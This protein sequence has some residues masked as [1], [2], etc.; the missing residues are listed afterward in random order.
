MP[1]LSPRD[2][3]GASKPIGGA[4]VLSPAKRGPISASPAKRG[5]SQ[6]PRKP[7][8][9]PS[10]PNSDAELGAAQ[11]VLTLPPIVKTASGS[12]QHQSPPA[13]PAH[14]LRVGASFLGTSHASTTRIPSTVSLR[15][16]SKNRDSHSSS[17]SP[18]LS[19]AASI[20]PGAQGLP[21][22]TGRGRRPVLGAD[23]EGAARQPVTGAVR[24]AARLTKEQRRERD[25]LRRQAATKIQQWYLRRKKKLDWRLIVKAAREYAMAEERR[26]FER[27]RVAKDVLRRFFRWAAWRLRIVKRERRAARQIE[28]VAVAERCLL[29]RRSEVIAHRLR[30]ER[31]A[32]AA[33]VILRRWKQSTA[34]ARVRWRKA[35]DAMRELLLAES[36]IERRDVE[37]RE[38]V[39]FLQMAA[40]FRA[41]PAALRYRDAINLDRLD[42]AARFAQ[43]ERNAVLKAAHVTGGRSRGISRGLSRATVDMAAD[44]SRKV[45]GLTRP[46]SQSHF[47]RP[48]DNNI[49]DG[50]SASTTAMSPG[51]LG[52]HRH[53]GSMRWTQRLGDK[54]AAAAQTRA[55]PRRSMS[56]SQLRKASSAAQ[57]GEL[58]VRHGSMCSRS[59]FDDRSSPAAVNSPS[60]YEPPLVNQG[61]DLSVLYCTSGSFR[62]AVM[63]SAGE[64]GADGYDAVVMAG[65]V[66]P[67]SLTWMLTAPLAPYT[68]LTSAALQAKQG[69]S[70]GGVGGPW[71]GWFRSTDYNKL[72][73][74]MQIVDGAA[75]LREAAHVSRHV[76]DHAVER[77]LMHETNRRVRLE[78]QV[79]SL[80]SGLVGAFLA[81]LRELRKL[82]GAL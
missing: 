78:V 59:A 54:I 81:E 4:K 9:A 17:Q 18:A 29:G 38:R 5:T 14:S 20:V 50:G 79:D 51:G 6:S 53:T 12:L 73:A 71:H 63:A 3:A 33:L 8:V 47:N 13:S 19:R 66:D 2:R 49:V 70:R 57:L 24:R 46:L 75:A 28:C 61:L 27:L 15:R 32:A 1:A 36:L 74:G 26:Q 37:R 76:H 48:A 80:A 25:E 45:G 82:E 23:K 40:P 58:G 72:N 43:H 16:A 39:A 7:T 56:L 77:L 34:F 62:D 52:D 10:V 22:M 11:P 30:F 55:D 68:A 60:R 21:A 31:M 69:S 42:E 44:G 64:A 41:A 35:N 67:S 65:A